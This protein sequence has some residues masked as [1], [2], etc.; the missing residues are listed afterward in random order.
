VL[1]QTASGTNATT[2]AA[3]RQSFPSDQIGRLSL[4]RSL[5]A[6]PYS[7]SDRERQDQMVSIRGVAITVQEQ[8]WC[9]RRGAACALNTLYGAPSKAGMPTIP[10]GVYASVEMNR[11]WLCTS[12]EVLP[13]RS[14]VIMAV[15]V[16]TPP[17]GAVPRA[18]AWTSS[19]WWR[20]LKADS[21]GAA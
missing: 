2:P 8:F 1:K 9:V 12:V 4:I 5:G 20:P 7:D 11:D 6:D 10:P 16:R 13:S 19:I 3:V 21:V 14:R 18:H 17:S 15:L